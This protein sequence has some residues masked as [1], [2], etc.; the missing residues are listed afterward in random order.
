MKTYLDCIPCFFRQALAAARMAGAS[1]RTQRRILVELGREIKGFSLDA[2]PPRM[3]ERTYALIRR[4]CG[5]DPFR[6]VKVKSN[7]HALGLY[8]PM[9]RK[10]SS[11]VDPLRT[12]ALLAIAG[13]VVD[14]GVTHGTAARYDLKKE[15]A[16]VLKSARG[17]FQYQE[18]TKELRRAGRILYLADNSGEIVFDRL[19][20][21]TI[22]N[23]Y[24]ASV[25][26]V[27]RGGP[28]INDA[29]LED[30]RQ[31]GLDGICRVISNGAAVPGTLLDRCSGEFLDAYRQAGLV[32]AKGQGNFE[33]L[34][35]EEKPR[36][37]LFK[38]KCDVIARYAGGRVGDAVL[39]RSPVAKKKRKREKKTGK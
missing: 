10:I 14:Y 30:A 3:A 33:S 12:A 29:T 2:S 6:K 8:P 27:V 7:E 34:W 11:A 39:I 38:I 35:G 4:H 22:K 5:S 18:F 15:L 19:L 37:F 31:V 32:I 24:P 9:R 20:I 26:A 1:E 17:V 25:T 13:N 21:E 36:Y 23:K 16:N 28:V